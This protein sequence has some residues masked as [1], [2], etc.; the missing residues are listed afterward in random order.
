MSKKEKQQHRSINKALVL[1]PLLQS[2]EW[3]LVVIQGAAWFYQHILYGD[4][5]L[6][7]PFK[8]AFKSCDLLH[9][10]CKSGWTMSELTFAL[11]SWLSLFHLVFHFECWIWRAE[12]HGLWKVV[13]IIQQGEKQ[14]HC[15]EPE[16]HTLNFVSM[17]DTDRRSTDTDVFCCMARLKAYWRYCTLLGF[18]TGLTL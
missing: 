18:C 6:C 1:S 13:P 16:Q 17:A 7:H 11:L 15:S 8:L 14:N 10:T 12:G 9:F 5:L 2:K 3:H 4:N